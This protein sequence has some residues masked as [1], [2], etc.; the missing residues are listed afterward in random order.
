MKSLERR[1]KKSNVKSERNMREIEYEH[2]RSN[3]R[4]K[5]VLNIM[6]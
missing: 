5:A 2:R 4:L 6:K 1:R 3:N